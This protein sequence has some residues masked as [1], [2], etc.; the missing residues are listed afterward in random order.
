M[1]GVL[2][3]TITDGHDISPRFIISTNA[4]VKHDA[5]TL[6]MFRGTV[7]TEGKS[8]S[9][10]RN[11]GTADFLRSDSEWAWYL[12]S[13]QVVRRDTLERLLTCARDR[14]SLI[15]GALTPIIGPDGPVPNLFFDNDEGP[16][17]FTT[18]KDYPD[19]AVEL[20]ATGA[21]CLLVHRRVLEALREAQGHEHWFGERLVPGADGGMC[22]IGEDVAFCESARELGFRIVVDCTTHVGHHKDNRV[23]W[24]EDIRR[25]FYGP[26]GEEVG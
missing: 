5:K 21:G 25:P 6:G 24:P 26:V 12:D 1:A 22:Q 23:W 9:R 7:Y 8:Y 17:R 15:I 18:P 20:A 10:G 11:L 4:L 14:E 16:G 19:E 3:L 13:D 2:M